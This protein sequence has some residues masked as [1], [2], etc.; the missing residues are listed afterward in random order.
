MQHCLHKKNFSY[1]ALLLAFAT[2]LSSCAF[3][4]KVYLTQTGKQG[5]AVPEVHGIAG[6]KGINDSLSEYFG[7]INA[8]L[9]AAGAAQLGAK[10][11]YELSADTENYSLQAWITG[12]NGQKLLF[13]SILLLPDG[14]R[15]PQT[16][17]LQSLADPDFL[18]QCLA[19]ASG[20]YSVN[21]TQI[22][23]PLTA[24]KTYALLSAY[25]ESRTGTAIDVSPVNRPDVSDAFQ[26]KALA[27]MPEVLEGF[28]PQDELTAADFAQSLS[29]LLKELLFYTYGLG[30]G[31]FGTLDL[32][33]LFSVYHELYALSIQ[34]TGH[35]A[36]WGEFAQ[37]V[38]ALLQN[39]GT[40]GYGRVGLTRGDM[41]SLFSFLYREYFHKQGQDE[42]M[43]SFVDCE[44]D[45]ASF[46]VGQGL[47]KPFPKE[48]MFYPA[49]ESRFYELPAITNDFLQA[50]FFSLFFS[51][52]TDKPAAFTE[53]SAVKALQS[54]DGMLSPDG[55][56]SAS[57]FGPVAA[58]QKSVRVNDR[59]YDWYF[60]QYNTGQY[61][62]VNCM[63]TMTAMALKW[64]NPGSTA[65]VESLR[66]K[67]LPEF[68][69]GWWM[70]Q[71]VSS[72][73]FY[74]VA[75]D[76]GNISKQLV[77]DILDRGGIVLAMFSEAEPGAQGHC[78]LIYGYERSGGSLRFL[79]QDPGFENEL[80]ADGNPRGKAR[81]LDA[82]YVVWTVERMNKLV[83][84]V[85]TN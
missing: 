33:R 15:L 40:D 20:G 85:G 73:D 76:Y 43:P 4:E 67:F 74:Q 32:D 68:A 69:D 84:S 26:L 62:A 44:N 75:Y 53:A 7:Q 21:L 8:A 39:T 83:V 16:D 10:V 82:D 77:V 22:N 34:G 79:V 13:D 36:L 52:E 9:Q 18:K 5:N 64:L 51:T 66:N 54:L 63:P 38:S 42:A 81:W 30:S 12:S 60:K 71:V 46:C 37:G 3:S 28:Y 80:R 72:L 61:A 14:L 58:E 48:N 57:A 47:M 49:Y 11:Q 35:E 23:K 55:T 1:I 50:C 45:N 31:G 2:L 25:Y 29:L 19:L 6:A 78:E 56:L 65:T 59:D 70:A 24:Q 17:F 27:L 41:A